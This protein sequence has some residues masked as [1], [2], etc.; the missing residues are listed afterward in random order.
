[1]HS[2]TSFDPCLS[3]II[4]ISPAGV[5]VSYGG[6]GDDSDDPRINVE[7]A[8]IPGTIKDTV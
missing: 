3:I 8:M 7:L 1:V 5:S 6:L 2:L 4:A